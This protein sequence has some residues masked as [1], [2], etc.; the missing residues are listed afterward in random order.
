MRAKCVPEG[1]KMGR[2]PTAKPLKRLVGVIGFEP[3]AP[4]SRTL[5]P[6]VHEF[7]LCTWSHQKAAGMLPK[8][9]FRW[10]V[11]NGQMRRRF[12]EFGFSV[13][14]M[15]ARKSGHGQPFGLGVFTISP[16]LSMVIRGTCRSGIER[17]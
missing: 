2:G 4:T 9:A 8:I 1:D 3:T 11:V 16:L 6:R 12:G 10:R 5:N 14:Q 7:F 13:R 17:W 15:R